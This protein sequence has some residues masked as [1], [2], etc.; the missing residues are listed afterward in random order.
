MTTSAPE[1]SKDKISPKR[2]VIKSSNYYP[3]FSRYKALY[4]PSTQIEKLNV[5][6]IKKH[7][8]TSIAGNDYDDGTFEELLLYLSISEIDSS[9]N[10]IQCVYEINDRDR[11]YIKNLFDI[12]E[13]AVFEGYLLEDGTFIPQ[14][15]LD[16]S[17]IHNNNYPFKH[18]KESY[19]R[20]TNDCDNKIQ[21][22]YDPYIHGLKIIAK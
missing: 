19:T 20:F 8:F 10:Y 5:Y 6:C 14:S 1:E 21:S 16:T 2:D 9:L 17:C 13:S 12:K 22:T 3:V 18:E 7:Y 4:N 15:I 11:L